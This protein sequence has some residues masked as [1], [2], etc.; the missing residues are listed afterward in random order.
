MQV[1]FAPEQAGD[2]EETVTITDGTSTVVITLTGTGW[3]DIQIVDDTFEY[4]AVTCQDVPYS[5]EY[6]DNLT[7]A[8]TYTTTVP[9]DLGGITTITLTLTVN[10]MYAFEEELTIHANDEGQWRGQDLSTFQPGEYLLTDSLVSMHGCDSVYVLHLE[11]LEV[12]PVA[13]PTYSEY[14]AVV[15]RGDSVEY[16]GQFYRHNEDRQIVLEGQN[17]QGGDSII[18]LLIRQLPAITITQSLTVQQDT[19]FVWQEQMVDCSQAGEQILTAAYASASSCDSVYVL[20]LV[21]EEKPLVDAL[22]QLSTAHKAK[23]IIHNGQVFILRDDQW[24]NVLGGKVQR[25]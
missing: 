18:H 10:P 13:E 19:E 1:Y 22:E 14:Q 7:L 16:L 4:T 11:V 25:Q 3:Q 21:V 15:C 23:K 17:Y 2:Y 8:D 20:N 5:D 9:N 12:L 6:F 24:F